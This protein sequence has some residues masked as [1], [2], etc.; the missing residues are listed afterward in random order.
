MTD[1][2][3]SYIRSKQVVLPTSLY[4]QQV[5]E[6]LG[7]DSCAALSKLFYPSQLSGTFRHPTALSA[8]QWILS[9]MNTFETNRT[10]WN[11][12]VAAAIYRGDPWAGSFECVTSQS[13]GQSTGSTHSSSSH[14][15]T[16]VLAVVIPIVVLLIIAVIV[17]AVLLRRK[18]S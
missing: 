16:I 4:I 14:T 13:T 17:A 18:R 8:T 9:G 11:T 3:R 15:R 10:D 2:N 12:T 7:N 1:R 5:K 6:R